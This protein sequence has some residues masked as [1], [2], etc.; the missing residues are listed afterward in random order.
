MADMR[1]AKHT[2][3]KQ[4]VWHLL[5]FERR[6][7]RLMTRPLYAA[8]AKLLAPYG[9]T[10]TDVQTAISAPHVDGDD[11][12]VQDALEKQQSSMRRFDPLKGGTK[13]SV[14]LYAVVRFFSLV[15]VWCW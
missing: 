1:F 15:L 10:A 6:A 14:P 3:T 11:R 9:G 2:Q 7:L 8:A 12:R 4:K 13:T 5:E